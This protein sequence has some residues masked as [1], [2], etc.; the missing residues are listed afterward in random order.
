MESLHIFLCR[1]IKKLWPHLCKWQA[2]LVQAPARVWGWGL[3]GGS[4]CLGLGCRWFLCPPCHKYFLR[5]GC[6]GPPLLLPHQGAQFAPFFLSHFWGDH[7]LCVLHYME[8]L[9]KA[10]NGQC[11]WHTSTV[12][13]KLLAHTLK[14]LSQYSFF[15]AL[16]YCT[17]HLIWKEKGGENGEN[18][19]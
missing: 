18:L 9:L 19:L 12:L 7:F 10:R 11:Y 13:L 1:E 16:I 15:W 8:V 4:G 14:E 2:A 5:L 17:H 3:E 6:M